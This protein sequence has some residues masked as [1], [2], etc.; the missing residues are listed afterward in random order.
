MQFYW[1][2]DQLKFNFTNSNDNVNKTIFTFPFEG[3]NA[4][5][6]KSRDLRILLARMIVFTKHLHTI[7][8][9]S[10]NELSLKIIKQ[11]YP[12]STEMQV[13]E[14]FSPSKIFCI[15][16]PIE[17]RT[18]DIQITV[19]SQFGVYSHYVEGTNDPRSNDN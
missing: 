12:V 10:E 6:W 16:S 5:L 11:V 3:T 8:L 1:E 15:K 19:N 9:S 17:Y 2:S 13:P 7:T 18:I 4:F 14:I